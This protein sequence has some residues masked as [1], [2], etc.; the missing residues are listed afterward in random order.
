MPEDSDDEPDN[1]QI[2]DSIQPDGFE[3][4]LQ[5][6]QE[7]QGLRRSLISNIN[8][9]STLSVVNQLHQDTEALRETRETINE[10]A[11]QMHEVQ[12]ELIEPVRKIQRQL[13]V[14]TDSFS[15]VQ[16]DL[17]Q[18]ASA[19]QSARAFTQAYNQQWS[20]IH[21]VIET[22][23]EEIRVAVE[24][25]LELEMPWEYES[26]EPDPA[27]KTAAENWGTQFLDEFDEVEDD[28]FEK[29]VNRIEHGLEEF[30]NEPER[31]YAAIH[32][33]ISMQDALL[34]WLCYQDDDIT[35]DETNEINLPKYGT[36]EKQDALRKH[37]H[38]YFGVEE[39]NPARISD[40]KWDCFW[41]HRHT[42]MHG[43]LY[44]TYDMNI[45]TT[46]LLF[47]ALTAHSVLHVI[48]EYDQEGENIPSIMDEI[49]QVQQDIETTD[50]EPS[51]A[52]GAF[53]ALQQTNDTSTD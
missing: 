16:A 14:A 41:A 18:A 10:H 22:L 25:Q 6:S 26:V 13:D 1:E 34:W 21:E 23:R 12:A 43:D 40:F 46:A 2:D 4:T 51:E 19:V 35:V 53:T 39:E 20:R 32:I 38:A 9:S 29:I 49:E 11:Q 28:Y 31:P 30:H 15:G 5:L 48:D 8:F 36:S 47:F 52:L 24:E 7:L 27:A 37:Y 45:A 42:I 50:V 44:A 3:N 17:Q 33:F